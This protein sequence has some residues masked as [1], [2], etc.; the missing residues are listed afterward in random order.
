MFQITRLPSGLHVC[1]DTMHDVETVT[2]GIWVGIG[3]HYERPEENGISHFLEHMVFKGTQKRSALQIS[4]EIEDVGGILNAYTSTTITAFHAKV[5]YKDVALAM[6]VLSDM[7]QNAAM[8][9]K[10]LE[11]ERN[12]VLQE[13]L[14]ENDTPDDMVFNYLHE[15]AYPGQSAGR[16]ILGTKETLTSLT[17]QDLANYLHNEYTPERVVVSAAGKIEHEELLRLVNR[18]LTQLR[19]SST[20]TLPT[21]VYH[22]GDYRKTKQIDQVNLVIGFQ[23]VSLH[24]ELHYAQAVLSHLF[25]GSMSSPLFQEIREKRG[26]VY[27]ISSFQESNTGLFGIYAGTGPVQ[28]KELVPVVC[29]LTKHLPETMTEKDIENAKTQIKAHILM[30]MEQTSTRATTPASQQITL[31]RTLSLEE[32]IQLIDDV[33]MSSVQKVLDIIL[34]SKPTLAAHGPIDALMPYADFQQALTL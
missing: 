18:Y 12:V 13:I 11:R 17:S 3:S 34:H 8:D 24:H 29:D 31:G 25:G 16:A 9:P 33:N 32:R 2:L 21:P 22:G 6:D 26:L 23:G 14:R 7:V 5:L 19:S 4:K 20:H 27:T 28:V 1:T 30:S 15:A 10:E